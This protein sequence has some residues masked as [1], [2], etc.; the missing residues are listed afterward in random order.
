[1]W[2]VIYARSGSAYDPSTQS[3]LYLM[4]VGAT[5]PRLT[6]GRWPQFDGPPVFAGFARVSQ[7]TTLSLVEVDYALHVINAL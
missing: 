5:R 3:A 1:M 6:D 2:V 4:Q 7:R